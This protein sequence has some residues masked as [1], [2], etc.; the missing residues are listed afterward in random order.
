MAGHVAGPGAPHQG[1]ENA[2]YVVTQ[3]TILDRVKAMEVSQ[4]LLTPPPGITL[5]LF[6]PDLGGS[7]AVCLWE[8]D[9]VETIRDLVDGVLGPYAQ[10]EFFPVHVWAAVGLR[11]ATSGVTPAL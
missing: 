4:S 2:V 10:N 5:H 7:K 11:A 3:H 9:S 6:L 8:A 1:E